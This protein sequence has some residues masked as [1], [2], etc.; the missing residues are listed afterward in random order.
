MYI[1]CKLLD[2]LDMPTMVFIGLAIHLAM[3]LSA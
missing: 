2:F 1:M 3:K